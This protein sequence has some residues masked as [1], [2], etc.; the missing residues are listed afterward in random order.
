MSVGPQRHRGG[1]GGQTKRRSDWERRPLTGF[2]V[3][4]AYRVCFV[5]G[6]LKNDPRGQGILMVNRN[7][8]WIEMF[9]SGVA[10]HSHNSLLQQ[11]SKKL[12]RRVAIGPIGLS[13]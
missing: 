3:T 2:V 10:E 4:G 13:H 9:F 6:L 8:K 5:M 7:Q 1:V 12:N 11:Y